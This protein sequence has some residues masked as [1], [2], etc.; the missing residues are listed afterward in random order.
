MYMCTYLIHFTQLG[1]DG[2]I[3][4]SPITYHQMLHSC[5]N[6]RC[7]T[8]LSYLC[9]RENRNAKL[10]VVFV[11]TCEDGGL[12]A[13]P[14]GPE[15]AEHHP[16]ADGDDLST[17][18]ARSAATSLSRRCSRSPGSCLAL[19]ASILAGA[20][21]RIVRCS[22][23]LSRSAT[24]LSYPDPELASPRAMSSAV[25]PSSSLTSR[26]MFGCFSSSCTALA[27]PSSTARWSD[28]DPRGQA[29][30]TSM[31]GIRCAISSSTT[32]L[33]PFTTAHISAENSACLIS[34]L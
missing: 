30:L 18:R 11:C 16:V 26:S 8:P 7:G 24:M 4:A 13:P 9:H 31:Y 22:T 6:E 28:V 21:W 25:S 32:R 19:G 20:E 2:Q 34:E 5:I 23:S 15:R 1:N 3:C 12:T 33:C 27:L 29:A 10:F 14:R 17:A